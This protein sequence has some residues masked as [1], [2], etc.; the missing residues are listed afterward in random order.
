[1]SECA[2]FFQIAASKPLSASLISRRGKFAGGKKMSVDPKLALVVED[3]P[4][5]REALADLLK[6]ERMDVIACDS[7]EAGELVLGRTG[8]EISVLITDV[9]L[10][11]GASGLE[12]AQFARDRFPHLKIIV[13]SGRTV[14]ELPRDICFL[15]KPYNADDLLRLTTT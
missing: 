3:D 15:R 13:V 7:A 8:L 10:A 12:L 9:E 2:Q 14:L 11:G 6:L 1:M 5:Q 4:S